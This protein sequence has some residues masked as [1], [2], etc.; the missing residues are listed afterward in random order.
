MG[1]ED[2]FR[3][4]ASFCRSLHPTTPSA[5]SSNP[6]TFLFFVQ[7]D[8]SACKSIAVVLLASVRKA[9]GVGSELDLPHVF[10]HTSD[11]IENLARLSARL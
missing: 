6:E 4:S 7:R 2:A 10:R 3:A 11:R 8:V 5:T 1:L 9:L